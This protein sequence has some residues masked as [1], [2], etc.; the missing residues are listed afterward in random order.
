MASTKSP[1]QL[2][3]HVA[4][5]RIAFGLMFA[6]NAM[7]KWLPDFKNSFLDQIKAAADGQPTWLHS[8]FNF[9]IQLFSH[10][11]H[12]FAVLVTL[13]ETA[14]A[15]ALIFGVAR[16]TV[17]LAATVFSLLIWSV[18]EG[19]GGPYSSASTDIGT[20]VIYAVVFLSL[21]GLD[22][23]AAQNSWSLDNYLVKRIPWWAIIA[24]P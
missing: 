20:G 12:L 15:L 10:N 3:K 8:W 9:W 22:R 4:I 2:S 16:R 11:P 1:V 14:I 6:V 23:L 5:L 7:F 21:Y 13:T 17:Y 18:P 24:N 19:F